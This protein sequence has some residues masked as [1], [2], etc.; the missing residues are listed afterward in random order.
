M[1]EDDRHAGQM[2]A[3]LAESTRGLSESDAAWQLLHFSERLEEQGHWELGEMTLLEL[4]EKYPRHPIAIEAKRRLALAWGSAEVTWRRLGTSAV[5]YQREQNRPDQSLPTAVQQAEA[6]LQQQSRKKGRNLFN[7]DDDTPDDLLEGDSGVI[8]VES[9]RVQTKNTVHKDLQ[10]K[11]RYWQAKSLKMYAD[12]ARQDPNLAATASFQFPLAAIYRLRTNHPKADEIYQR[13]AAAESTS[14]W[15]LAARAEVWL[16][17]TTVLPETPIARCRFTEARPH[18]DG[19]LDDL[20]WKE[21]EEFPLRGTPSLPDQPTAQIALCYDQEYLYVAARV[22]RIAGFR[23]D[24]KPPRTRRHDEDLDD[25]DRIALTLDVDRDYATS[26]GLTF[27]QRGCT[28]DRCSRDFSWNPHWFVAT[29]GDEREW[30][31]EAAITLRDLVPA[32]PT[33]DTTW[34]LGVTRIVPGVRIENWSGAPFDANGP[35]S[36]GLLMFEA[37]GALRAR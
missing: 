13:F 20:C 24:A 16:K 36:T 31:V 27:D 32:S 5:E 1:L 10:Q 37:P 8:Q 23:T 21:A 29:A 35:E 15:E 26:F 2:I 7:S 6:R 30:R 3:Q 14:A 12:L 4:A 28:Q 18:L 34:A 11:Q 33:G 9:Q 22:P 25:F 19:N 17:D